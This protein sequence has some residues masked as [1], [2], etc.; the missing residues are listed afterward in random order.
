MSMSED[1]KLLMGAGALVVAGAVSIALVASCSAI[2]STKGDVEVAEAPETGHQLGGVAITLG[3]GAEAPIGLRGVAA[4]RHQ[5]A[6]A[7][8]GPAGHPPVEVGPAG[9]D[10]GDV[11]GERR[12][13][14]LLELGQ[15]SLGAA[16]VAAGG[17]VGQGNEIRP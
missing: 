7:G 12:A 4:Q 16:L 9:A 2:D 1:T 8:G 6:N 5:A 13:G 15:E 17:A 14:A 10:R 3:M 11:G